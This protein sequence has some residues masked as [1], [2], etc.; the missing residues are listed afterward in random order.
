MSSPTTA[1]T[2]NST[3]QPALTQQLP[4]VVWTY[5]PCNQIASCATDC[6]QMPNTGT[7]GSSSPTT[8]AAAP[9][10][11]AMTMATSSP[12]CL[13]LTPNGWSANQFNPTVVS[14]A[15]YQLPNVLGGAKSFNCEELCR[16]LGNTVTIGNDAPL[17]IPTEYAP[18]SRPFSMNRLITKTS[19]VTNPIIENVMNGIKLKA[20][21]VYEV[22]LSFESYHKTINSWVKLAVLVNR[23]VVGYFNPLTVTMGQ[24]R[25]IYP[26]YWES[27]RVIQASEDLELTVMPL[28]ASS[29]PTEQVELTNVLL[30]VVVIGMINNGC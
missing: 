21:F 28:E 29:E 17:L 24:V 16:V 4:P 5:G 30:Q 25:E 7:A 6:L 23:Q 13:T 22:L 19:C 9:C 3:T 8:T 14:N 15:C 10:Q 2:T 26:T 1:T 20:G 27:K 12:A 18:N 11:S